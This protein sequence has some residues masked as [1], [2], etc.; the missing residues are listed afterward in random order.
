MSL[1]IQSLDVDALYKITHHWQPDILYKLRAPK[2][3][4]SPGSLESAAPQRQ[5][6]LEP[7]QK[8]VENNRP[9]FDLFL[10]W[11]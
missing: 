2:E 11:F 6:Q 10:T 4:G 5:N 1:P 3:S 8:Q 9:D 7:G